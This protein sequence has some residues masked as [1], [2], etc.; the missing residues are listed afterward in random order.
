M[1]GVIDIETTG[2]LNKGGFIV[3]V[4]IVSLDIQSGDIK[5]VFDSVCKEDGMTAKDREAWI[6]SNSDL[7]VDEVRNAPNF[8]EIMPDIQLTID[9]FKHVTAFNKSFDFDFLRDR[10][11]NIEREISCPMKILTPVMK[12]QKTGKAAF[13]GGYKWPNVE[14]AWKYFFPDDDYNELHRGADDAVHEA[15]I[16][17]KIIK[18]GIM[19]V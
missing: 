12:L 14:E 11:V 7:T 15:M 6:F 13:Y 3:E 4:G 2:F 10:G 8:K 1:I 16:I 17:H 19:E 5:V 18:E 9:G